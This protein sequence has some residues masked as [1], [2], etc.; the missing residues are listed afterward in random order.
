MPERFDLARRSSLLSLREVALKDATIRN[1]AQR[2]TLDPIDGDPGTNGSIAIVESPASSEMLAL[3]IKRTADVGTGGGAGFVVDECL[4]PDAQN[5]PILIALYVYSSTGT[6]WPNLAVY[7]YAGSTQIT[8]ASLS[9]SSYEEISPNFRRYYGSGT[10]PDNS[11]IDRIRYGVGVAVSGAVCKTGGLTVITGTAGLAIGDIPDRDWYGEDVSRYRIL[12]TAN[13]ALPLRGKRVAHIGDSIIQ[14]YGITD[15]L[16]VATGGNWV[17][18]GFGGC[19][20]APSATPGVPSD[21]TTAKDW[22]SG[23]EIARA[24]STGD[25]SDQE[26]AADYIIDTLGGTPGG[27]DD[28]RDIVTFLSGLDWSAIDVFIISHGTNDFNAASPLGTAASMTIT[29]FNGAINKA[30]DLLQTAFKDKQIVFSTPMWRGPNATHGDSNVNPN[31]SGIFLSEYQDAISDRCSYHNLP[32]FELH[33]VFGANV[34]NADRLL[35]AGHLHP[36]DPRGV[37][38]LVGLMASWFNSTMGR[39]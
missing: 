14:L 37:D 22:F 4:G 1:R 36:E 19:R 33:K 26:T 13:Q 8:G 23:V 31:G 3:G 34:Y 35:D 20:M 25:W 39:I 5:V 17:N 11:G 10:T 9:L 7:Y 32:V 16:A 30:V 15:L 18:A 27:N 28:Y 29:D 24:I 2:P 12:R 6:D 38:R 21:L